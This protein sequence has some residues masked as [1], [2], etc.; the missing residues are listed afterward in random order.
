M[1]EGDNS[2][3]VTRS[4]FEEFLHE[5][6]VVFSQRDLIG[7]SDVHSDQ[8]GVVLILLTVH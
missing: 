3:C 2:E 7:F 6:A 5:P 8:V 4:Y 1:S